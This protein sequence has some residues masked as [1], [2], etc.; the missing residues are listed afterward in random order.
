MSRVK[1][2][3]TPVPAASQPDPRVARFASS[4]QV[5]YIRS[6][7]SQ[8]NISSLSEAQQL[9]LQERYGD[10]PFAHMSMLQAS[11]IIDVLDALPRKSDDR[12]PTTVGGTHVPRIWETAVPQGRYAVEEEGVLK[13]FHVDKPNEGRWS[14]YTFIKIRASDELYRVKDTARCQNILKLIEEKGIQLCMEDYGKML[15]SCGNCG[16]TLTDPVSRELGIG[17]VCRGRLGWY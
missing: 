8:R 6:L 12:V 1:Y 7:V 5:Q 2:D 9:F 13:F 16:R 15:G 3:T 10:V 4:A 11:K 17:P 14:G